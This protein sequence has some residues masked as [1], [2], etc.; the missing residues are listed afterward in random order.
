[1]EK[2]CKFNLYMGMVTRH[3]SAS[4]GAG[5]LSLLCNATIY[6][7]FNCTW[8]LSIN[9]VEHWSRQFRCITHNMGMESTLWSEFIISFSGDNNKL[10]NCGCC[11]KP[12]LSGS[13]DLLITG[14]IA[15][16]ATGI[17]LSQV[18][19]SKGQHVPQDGPVD[20]HAIWLLKGSLGCIPAW[21]WPIYHS[22]TK[23]N[24]QD[25][26]CREGNV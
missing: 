11:C 22:R 9:S 19:K 7:E 13:M 23:G 16:Y 6:S 4:R 18:W 8:Q 17:S 10:P 21:L 3:S 20:D 25:D 14:G 2:Y 1:M 12:E 26:E 5:H 15:K 24:S